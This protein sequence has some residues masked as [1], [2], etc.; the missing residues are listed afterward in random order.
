MQG[1]G[2]P[3]LDS[4]EDLLQLNGPDAL[5]PFIPE[6]YFAHLERERVQAMEDF[7]WSWELEHQALSNKTT[8]FVPQSVPIGSLLPHTPAPTSHVV[9]REEIEKRRQDSM[10][11]YYAV[12]ETE[13]NDKQRMPP[14]KHQGENRVRFYLSNLIMYRSSLILLP[15]DRVDH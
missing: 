4:D 10:G 3:L 6:E 5:E 15:G 9:S 13:G 2:L 8:P 1:T 11:Y 12:K 14:T 7:V